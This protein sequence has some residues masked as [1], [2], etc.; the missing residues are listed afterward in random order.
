VLVCDDALL[1][2]SER[3]RQR[4]WGSKL[5]DWVVF[6]QPSWLTSFCFHAILLIVL[7]LL[8]IP[9]KLWE[10]IVL[11][12]GLVGTDEFELEE[13]VSTVRLEPLQL[14]E[15]AWDSRP[16]EPQPFTP[17]PPSFTEVS[18]GEWTRASMLEL[19]ASTSL[20]DRI[21]D[22]LVGTPGGM[23]GRVG[24]RAGAQMRGASKE[25]E[26]AVDRALEW[27]A[28]HQNYDGSWTFDLDTGRCRGSCSHSGSG[29][30]AK[31]AATAL[32]LLPFLGAGNTGEKGTYRQ[33]VS[34][35]LDY[36]MGRQGRDGGFLEPKG[37]MYSHG[38]VALALCE[39]TAMASRDSRY[40]SRHR[41]REQKLRRAAQQAID[42]I[43]HSQHTGGG[44]RYMPREPG[45]TSVVGWQAMAL[46]SGRMAGLH[47]PEATLK[48]IAR[49]L[50][51]VRCDDYGATYGYMTPTV[52]PATTA[53]GLL[54]RMY[55]GWKRSHPGI[56]NGAE[57]L[58]RRG[59]SRN[60][61]YY[62]Y[63]ATQVLH[64]YQG[65]LWEEWNA[66]MRDHLV[67]TQ[68]KQGHERGSWYFDGDFGSGVGGRLY[69][70]AMS[71]MVLE[72]YYRHMPIYS[73]QAFEHDED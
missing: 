53:V 45:D 55:L 18:L 9:L 47:F 64:H 60:N 54:S 42:F 46:Q 12:S 50:D 11:E 31:N 8:V 48:G 15:I 36:L 57:Y 3:C 39:A 5:F 58:S 30:L 4:S 63:Y 70:T 13:L 21:G 27:L 32:G 6:K 65:P 37:T 1:R 22:V 2:Y 41:R 16:P 20:G 14:D 17:E 68:V 67:H 69:I 56:I 29:G 7:G 38:L 52:R 71:A 66:V 23:P 72:V 62:N 59:P 49:F 44:W 24:R 26:E 40:S 19:P 10:H 43:V 28:A 33:T 73:L 25:S 61:V 51:G 35:A 34:S